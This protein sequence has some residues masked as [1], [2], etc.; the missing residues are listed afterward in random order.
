[1]GNAWEAVVSVEGFA[2]L[3][4]VL[5]GGR[6][7]AGAKIPVCDLFDAIPVAVLQAERV[8]RSERTA[9]RP[10]LAATP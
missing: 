5:V 6:R 8:R 10:L 9:A 4:H 7:M 3:N 2:S 1:M